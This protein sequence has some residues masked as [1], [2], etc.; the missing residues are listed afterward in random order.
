MKQEETGWRDG[1]IS[2]RHRTWGMDAPAVDIDWL[3]IE[4]SASQPVA[5]IDWKAF[6]SPEANLMSN[7]FRALRSLANAAGIPLM[8]VYYQ[9]QDWWF[10]VV[11]ANVWAVKW[12]PN[13]MVMSEREFVGSLYA[14][15][16]RV[17]PKA[18]AHRLETY[19]PQEKS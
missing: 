4:Y 5:I 9:A 18:L 6:G 3:L 16:G 10:R 11:P 8:I 13:E 17:F 12:Y 1:R 14:M 2:Q 15:R 7:N 19:K